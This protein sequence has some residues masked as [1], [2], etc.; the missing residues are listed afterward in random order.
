MY[1]LGISGKKPLDMLKNNPLNDF[2]MQTKVH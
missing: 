2:L 1:L